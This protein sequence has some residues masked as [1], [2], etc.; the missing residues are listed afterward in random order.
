MEARGYNPKGKRS[1]YRLFKFHL[2]DLFAFIIV[3][4]IFGSLL[5][6]LIF[7]KQHQID[8]IYFVF[9]AKVGF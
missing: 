7:D 5:T 2:S 6:L 3:G 8:I 9:G 4:L 1:K